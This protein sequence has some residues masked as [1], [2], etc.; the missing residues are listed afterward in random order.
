ML[1]HFRIRIISVSQYIE[2]KW[3]LL[4]QRCVAGH[5]RMR[6]SPVPQGRDR[7]NSEPRNVA[8]PDHPKDGQG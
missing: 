8:T 7:A 3:C 2:F 6:V 4:H 5:E 1:S